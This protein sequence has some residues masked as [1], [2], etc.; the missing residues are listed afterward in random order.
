MKSVSFRRLTINTVIVGAG[1]WLA[2]I[3]NVIILPLALVYVSPDDFG[4]YSLL[5]IIALIGGVVLSFGLYN[6]FIARFSDIENDR[7]NLLGRIMGQQAVFGGVLL[8]VLLP[9]CQP[10]M[11]GLDINQPVLLLQLFLLGEYFANM[12]LIANR[13]QILTNH[14]WQLSLTAFIRSVVQL[15][16]MFVFVVWNRYGLLGLVMADFGSK[17]IAFAVVCLLT[18]HSWRYE[19]RNSDIH[20][21]FRLGLPSMPDP[22]FFWLILFL[23]LYML[24]QNSLLAMAGAFSLGWR[25]MSPVELFGNSLASAAASKMVDK[26]ANQNSLNGWYRLSVIMIILVS[27]GLLFFSSEIF[28]LFFDPEYYQII[29]FL[30]FLTGGVM[31][32]ALYYFEWISLSG[33]GRTYG[34]SLASGAGAGMMLMGVA[35]AGKTFNGL[36]ATLLFALSFFT[37]WGVARIINTKQRFGNWVYLIGV[38]V[39][40]IGIGWMGVSISPSWQAVAVKVISLGLIALLML[41]VELFFYFKNIDLQ[42]YKD[43]NVIS[44][45]NYSEIAKKISSSTSILDIGCSEGFFLG[46][47]R[48]SGMKVGV[49]NDFDRLKAG[50][51]RQP[52]INF[53]HADSSRLPFRDNSFGTVVLIGVL[54]YLQDPLDTLGES[55]RVMSIP[56]RVEI[57]T[58]NKKWIYRFLNIYNWKHKFHFYSSAELENVMKSAGFAIKSIYMRGRIIAPLLGSLFIIPNM[59]DRWQGN[60]HS[61]LGPWAQL[62]RRITNPI[63]QWEYDHLGGEGYQYF[64]TGLRHE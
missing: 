43:E 7:G 9:L 28:H 36:F 50:R 14:H 41:G 35:L 30:P 31:F 60:G 33:S 10:I 42:E 18:R 21:V 1:R 6:A 52:A 61:V 32:L 53:V 62:A 19:F 49:D 29:P 25:L 38:V 22:V 13:W 2:Q 23:P 16:L 34:L 48:V 56:G 5:Q 46:A 57:S 55:H 20:I 54:P 37:M 24:K 44:I 59:I 11:D 45:P 15:G 12:V 64:V 40:V 47:I 51:L 4:I 58:V 63:I 26:D 17:L 3:L 8:A 27:M 39:L